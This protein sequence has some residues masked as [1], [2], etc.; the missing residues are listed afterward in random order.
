VA[1]SGSTLRIVVEHDNTSVVL[2]VVDEGPGLDGEQRARAFD[3]FWQ[4]DGGNR[5]SGLG[6]AIIRRLAAASGARV[7]L[8]S[9]PGGGIDA[10][11]TFRTPARPA[12]GRHPPPTAPLK[13]EHDVAST[14]GASG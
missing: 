3:R 8:R 7:E 10:T 6:L 4:A 13:V 1:P 9:A 12:A 5:G 14:R 11:A 2:H